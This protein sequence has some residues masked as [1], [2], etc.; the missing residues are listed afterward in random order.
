MFPPGLYFACMQQLSDEQLVLLWADSGE[1]AVQQQKAIDELFGRYQARV[2]LWC[3]RVA[4]DRDLAADLAQE[5]FMRAFRSLAQFRGESKF[6]TWL[7]TITR[8][9]CFNAIRLRKGRAEQ[10]LEFVDLP[11]IKTRGAESQAELDSE[12]RQ[13]RELLGSKLDETER[14]VM[15]L[16]YAEEMSLESITGLLGLR[17]ASGAKAYI[18]SARR[19]LNVAITRLK[20]RGKDEQRLKQ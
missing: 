1:G 17:N 10:S 8:N 2:A 13:M 9:H 6:S 18:V 15:T 19:K 7:Y 4:R 16:H 12:V 20:S 5:V 11:D 14:Q 3:F